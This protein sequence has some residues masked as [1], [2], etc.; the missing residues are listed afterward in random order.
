M[1]YGR[2]GVPSG[3]GGG[4][5][6]LSNQL[7][8]HTSNIRTRVEKLFHSTKIILIFLMKMNTFIAE[9][10]KVKLAVENKENKENEFSSIQKITITMA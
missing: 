7:L 2:Y 4:G 6:S 5:G 3:I 10:R 1:N 8:P 9:G